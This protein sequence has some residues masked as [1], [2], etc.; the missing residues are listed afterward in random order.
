MASTGPASRRVTVRRHPERSRYDRDTIEAILDEG[1]ICHLGVSVDGEAHVIPTMYARLGDV[2]YVH[3][4]MA[5]QVLGALRSGATASLVVTHL[6]GLV[7]ARSAFHHSMNYRSVVV[8]GVAVEVTDHEEKVRAMQA[9]LDQVAPG[10]WD[11]SRQPNAVEI[12][13]TV[14][15]ALGLNEASAKV[16]TGPPLDDP[17]DLSLPYWAGVIPLST[18]AGEPVD[19]PLLASGIPVPAYA[20]GY[21][22]PKAS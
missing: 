12:G 3:G 15:L 9:L 16:R 20:R 1:L 2:V 19:D 21:R 5:N 6:D 18:V 13:T 17:D 22:R 11:S 7:M 4:A 8:V 14:I 10:R